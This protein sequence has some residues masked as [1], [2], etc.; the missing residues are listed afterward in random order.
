MSSRTWTSRTW[1]SG[2]LTSATLTSRTRMSSARVRPTAIVMAIVT[3]IGLAAASSP[4]SAQTVDFLRGEA[5]VSSIVRDAPYS[6]DGETRVSMTL[7][8]GTRIERRVTA[9]FYRDSDGRVRREQT[10][11]G[12][13][14]LN[15][16]SDAERVVTIV[17]PVAGSVYALNPATRVAWRIPMDRRL[18][19]GTPPPPPPPPPPPAPSSSPSPSPSAGAARSASALP[20]PPPPAAPARPIEES[21]GTREIAGVHTVGRRTRQTIPAGQI[22]NDRP[23]DIT[24]ERWES[25]E[26]K[27]LVFSRHH[28]PRTGDIEFRLTNLTRT[29]P[30]RELFTVPADYTISDAPP[31]PPPPPP[32]PPAL[33]PSTAST[34]PRP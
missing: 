3:A 12:L 13:A 31:L 24:D 4:A 27:L 15:P 18:L 8:D 30:P 9:R 21:L 28:D 34:R 22:G 2:M 26:L 29:D 23:I 6:G 14:A 5:A 1:M 7:H 11:M 25:P 17:D 10:V 32:P 33:T 20:P 16:S 19:T